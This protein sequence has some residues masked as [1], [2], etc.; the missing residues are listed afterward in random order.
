MSAQLREEFR[1]IADKTVAIASYEDPICIGV[2]LATL[3]NYLGFAMQAESFLNLLREIENQEVL[4]E[5]I[6]TEEE[7]VKWLHAY[8]SN[9]IFCP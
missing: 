3:G 5:R 9:C 7:W 1:A 8:H 2:T 4:L 6:G